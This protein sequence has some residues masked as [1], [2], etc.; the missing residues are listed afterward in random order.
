MIITGIVNNAVHIY[1]LLEY[2]ICTFFQRTNM[3]QKSF[4]KEMTLTSIISMKQS[5]FCKT[6]MNKSA[7]TKMTIKLIVA[8]H[9]TVRV[10]LSGYSGFLHH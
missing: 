3:I 2:N 9:L 5:S 4:T 6:V 8:M 7:Y 1:P 10:V